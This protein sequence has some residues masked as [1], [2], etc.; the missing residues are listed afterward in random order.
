M[1][2]HIAAEPLEVLPKE[3]ED[4]LHASIWVGTLKLVAVLWSVLLVQRAIRIGQVL[5]STW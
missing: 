1:V 3:Q 5:V 2:E 4:T